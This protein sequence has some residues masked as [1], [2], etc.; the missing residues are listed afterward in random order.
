L[1]EKLSR[2]DRVRAIVRAI[3][4]MGQSANLRL[5]AE[6]IETAE[7][8]AELTALGCQELQGFLFGKPVQA[9]IFAR[10]YLARTVV[11]DGVA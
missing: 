4:S 11:H 10:G 5:V 8:A 2:N 7:Q 9:D 1:V 6:G 3:T